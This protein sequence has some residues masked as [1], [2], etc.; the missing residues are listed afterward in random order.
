MVVHPQ[1]MDDIDKK[2][3]SSWTSW[4]FNGTCQNGGVSCDTS[5]SNDNYC[6]ESNPDCQDCDWTSCVDD[7]TFLT[8]LYDYMEVRTWSDRELGATSVLSSVRVGSSFVWL[9]G[10]PIAIDSSTHRA[11]TARDE[12]PIVPPPEDLRTQS[13]TLRP[14][15]RP[16]GFVGFARGRRH[17]PSPQPVVAVVAAGSTRGCACAF[18]ATV[19]SLLL[20]ARRTIASTST[21]CTRP[22][23]RT[24]V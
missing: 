2:N 22:A 20:R 7:V 12:G 6:Y 24:A 11:A 17:H 5:K 13:G 3:P 21:A 23:S 14:P 10:R 18:V 16:V 15:P 19:G 4:H 8:E 1:G 9:V